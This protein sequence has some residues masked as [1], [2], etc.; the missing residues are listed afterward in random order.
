MSVFS[1][2]LLLLV[3]EQLR[4]QIVEYGVLSRSLALSRRALQITE[5]ATAGASVLPWQ[6][7][8]GLQG[9]SVISVT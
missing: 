2:A 9:P 7:L 3:R 6:G 1:Y 5:H 8:V 4:A